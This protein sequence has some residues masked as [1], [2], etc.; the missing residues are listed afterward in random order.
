MKLKL[1]LTLSVFI[2]ARCSVTSQSLEEQ[3]QQFVDDNNIPGLA[4]GLIKYDALVYEGY[5]GMANIETE[6]PVAPTTSF[7]LASM[8]K[9][10]THCAANIAVDEGFI[11]SLDDNV[12][13][14]LP[15]EL[16]HPFDNNTII[17]LR[18]LLNHTSGIVDNWS[19]MPYLDSDEDCSPLGV[20]LENYLVE[21]GN[22][23]NAQLNYNVNG[24][25]QDIYS[26]IGYALAG[27]VVEAATGIDFGQYVDD[28]IFTPLCMDN[29]SFYFN[30]LEE[31]NIAIPYNLTLEA[32]GHYSYNDYPSGRM[33]STI[34]DLANYAICML[35]DGTMDSTMVMTM[36][37]SNFLNDGHGGYDDGVQTNLTLN[38]NE[39]ISLVLLM[40]GTNDISA[41]IPVLQDAFNYLDV[42]N[43]D[44]LPCEM[45]VSTDENANWA[46]KI[47]PNP[48][49]DFLLIEW[50]GAGKE[51]SLHCFDSNGR[52]VQL[53]PIFDH[54]KA[55]IDVSSISNGTYY[56]QIKNGL[57]TKFSSSFIK[58]K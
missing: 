14:Y 3:I 4:V 41:L 31:S 2:I 19:E 43:A 15:F 12:N 30:Q 5:F 18:M 35:G 39:D 21:G 17:T 48:A 10:F 56:F 49:Q 33:R 54:N 36:E 23:F 20:Y 58:M 44:E 46:P 51:F 8:S 16:V 7:M 28:K 22:I 37:A 47:Y 38:K 6:T 50:D 26:N 42:T 13:D 45:S 9:H 11:S 27:F 55:E 24:T 40:N 32:I 52:E 1:L 53:I 57:E 34:R 25:G 29:S